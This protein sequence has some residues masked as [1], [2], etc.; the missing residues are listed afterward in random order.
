MSLFF[1]VSQIDLSYFNFK[2]NFIK[3]KHFCMLFNLCYFNGQ[4][5]PTTPLMNCGF[6]YF[7]EYFVKQMKKHKKYWFSSNY[8]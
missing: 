3:I 1:M 6:E 5:V 8:F 2:I 4:F 7:K